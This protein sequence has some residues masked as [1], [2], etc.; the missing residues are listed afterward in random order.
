MTSALRR[1]ATVLIIA[2]ATVISLTMGLRS[3]FG[4]FQAPISAD[5]GFSRASFGFA[6]AMQQLLW[7]LFQ[8]FCGMVADRYGSGR[9]LVAGAAAYMAGLLVMAGSNDIISFNIGAGWLIGFG[10]SATSFS[11]VLGALGRLVAPEK[12]SVAFGIATAGGSVGQ[13]FMAPVGQ[14]LIAT[15]GWSGALVA[16]SLIAAL[17]ALSGFFLQSKAGDEVLLGGGSTETADQ[18]IRQ[19]V[20]EACNDNSY[21]YLTLGFF[22]CGFQVS[23]ITIHLPSYLLDFGFTAQTGAISLALIGFFNIIGTYTCG[24]LGGRYPKRYLLSLLYFLRSVVVLVFLIMPKTDISV[25]L[26][27][28]AMGLLW[29][30]TVP[31]TSGLVAQIFGPRYMSTLFG[32]VFLSH[33]IGSFIGV[34]LGGYLFD[35]TGSY[36]GIWYGSIVLGLAAAL[37]HLP[38]SEKPFQ[39]AEAPA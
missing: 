12:R 29:L 19:A 21:R 33:Q 13:F 22:V 18:T 34:W 10:L 1:N 27:A 35:T 7:G 31:L 9:V 36:D 30:G 25:Y 2:A 6:M 5:L 37:L 26:F 32:I 8:P 16:M 28:A 17:M 3:T 4:L 24:V 20:G 11:V 38:I 39:R 14:Q 23:F 15:Q